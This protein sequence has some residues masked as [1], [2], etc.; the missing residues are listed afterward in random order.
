MNPSENDKVIFTSRDFCTDGETRSSF[1]RRT[2]EKPKQSPGRI[3]ASAPSPCRRRQEPILLDMSKTPPYARIAITL[4][5]DTLR[6][7]DELAA[8]QDRSRS[9]IVA[10][11][12]RQYAAAQAERARP[13]RSEP[14][15]SSSFDEFLAWQRDR[16]VQSSSMT[17]ED[18]RSLALH[19]AIAGKLRADPDA[20]LRRARRSVSRMHALHA[21]ARPLLEEWT[22]L[23]DRPL[24]VLLSVLRDTSAK[25][26]ELRHVTP[27]AGVL[28]AR[29]RTAVYRAFA[30]AEARRG[31]N[32]AETV[33]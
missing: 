15:S 25:S 29:E 7:A 27:F 13:T 21:G 30:D 8:Q 24:P 17:R 4:P 23:L 22:A 6:A 31:A 10:E 1:V 33:S 18:R 9:W 32:H 12:I 20:T 3:V 19:E 2:V 11:A 5:P 14:L 16:A 26:R 28:S